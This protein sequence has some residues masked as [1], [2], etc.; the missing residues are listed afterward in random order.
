MCSTSFRCLRK[1]NR[2]Q[3][4]APAEVV[5]NPF[6][7]LPRVIEIEH[8][9]DRVHAQ[10]VEVILVDPEERVRE[11]KIL[12]FVAAVVEDQRAPV[13]MRALARIGVLVEMRAVEERQA[14]RVAREMRGR[15]IENHADAFLMAAIDEVHEIFRRAEAA[16]DREISDGLIAPGLV[17]RML[18]DGHQLDV[19]VAHLLDVGNQLIG[20]F[21]IGEPAI[22]VVAS[23]PPRAEMHFVN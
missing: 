12:H 6:A 18:H 5:G 14:V 19:R 7:R 3:I 15:P 21:A 23:S 11:Q 22:S 9:G 10:A 2:F 16:G 8:R 13:G 1:R 17:E 4:L 20:E